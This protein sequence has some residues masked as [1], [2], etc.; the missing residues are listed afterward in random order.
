LAQRVRAAL[1][2]RRSATCGCQ[3]GCSFAFTAS[4]PVTLFNGAGLYKGIS[5]TVNITISFVGVGPRF[6]S[7]TKKGKCNFSN[8]AKPLASSGAISGRGTVKFS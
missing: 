7:G 6:T 5:G 3:P 4:G 2:R 1:L 8:I